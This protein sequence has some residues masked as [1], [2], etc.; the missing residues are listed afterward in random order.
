MKTINGLLSR[1]DIILDKHIST[2]KRAFEEAARL[3]QINHHIELMPVVESLERREKLGSTALGDGVALPHARLKDL[4]Y[5]VAAFVRSREPIPFGSMDGKPV[6]DIFVLLVPRNY[7][8]EQSRVLSILVEFFLGPRFRKELRLCADPA[9]V[10]L[11]F[12]ERV[13]SW[14]LSSV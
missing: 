10:H 7:V 14:P 11:L 5:P 8:E 4:S 9:S 13:P 1:E 3:F 6:S 2:G 12:T